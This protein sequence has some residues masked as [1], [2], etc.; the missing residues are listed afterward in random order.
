M[1][2]VAIQMPAFKVRVM[3][4]NP[5]INTFD[6]LPN[7]L[8]RWKLP[9][10]IYGNKEV[11]LHTARS[12]M[13]RPIYLQIDRFYRRSDPKAEKHASDIVNAIKQLV[14]TPRW[15][16]QFGRGTLDTTTF[17]QSLVKPNTTR[18]SITSSLVSVPGGQRER[19]IFIGLGLD[20]EVFFRIVTLEDYAKARDNMAFNKYPNGHGFITGTVNVFGQDMGFVIGHPITPM[21]TFF[22]GTDREY[23]EDTVLDTLDDQFPFLKEHRLFHSM[24]LNLL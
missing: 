9:D 4:D 12:R 8:I 2:Y 14:A 16:E 18:S 15:L 3:D 13:I 24:D 22:D 10:E 17:K 23:I 19:R 6:D 5:K 21:R 1:A 11:G 20:R 7:F